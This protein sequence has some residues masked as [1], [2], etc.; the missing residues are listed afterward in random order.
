MCPAADIVV[1]GHIC[2]DII[3][4]FP[5]AVDNAGRAVF[6]PGGMTQMLPAVTATGG[7]VSN[8]GLA[9]HRL[10]VPTRL[11]GKVGDDVLGQATLDIL[12]REAPEL[13]DG[14]VVAEG[15]SSSYSV[16]LGPPGLDRCFLHYPGPNE[17]YC[18]DDIDYDSLAGSRL[19][20]FGYPTIM[21][22][23]RRNNGAELRRM[24][25]AAKAQGL[26]TS[27]DMS[28]PDPDSD[29]GQ[30]DW[31]ALLTNVLP[32]VDL[33]IPSLPETLFMLDRERFN[34]LSTT[35]GSPEIT[36]LADGALLHGV[37]DQLLGMG[38]AVV[39]LKL[40]D[41][42]IYVRTTPDAQRIAAAGH[43]LSG[44]GDDWL[45]RE[46][47]APCFEVEVVGTTGAGDTTIAG[48]LA[49]LAHGLSLDAALAAATGTGAFCVEQ[50]DAV[51]GIPSW[52]V[53][54]QRISAG[55]PRREITLSMAH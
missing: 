48:F 8:T 45:G 44:A 31:Q 53:L 36:S 11:M 17:T 51:S 38:V 7:V 37:A 41:Q 16:V 4:T 47:L 19:F 40:G 20:H 14:M 29:A 33:F 28:T 43:G 9:C 27:L 35:L 23:V 1:A 49:G 34:K 30:T 42:G 21:A 54:Q 13:A 55:W 18:A 50:A 39:G 32:A 26:T 25:E 52:E 10:G 5:A 6:V 22:T 2:L 46:V 24:F 12:R 3:P 15:V